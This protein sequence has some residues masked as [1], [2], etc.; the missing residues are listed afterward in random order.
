MNLNSLTEKCCKIN[1]MDVRLLY[2]VLPEFLT[3][4][5]VI[6][7]HLKGS[8]YFCA[9]S[10][11]GEKK[12]AILFYITLPA[13]VLCWDQINTSQHSAQEFIFLY[14]Q[15][16]QLHSHLL[17]CHFHRLSFANKRFHTCS[18]SCSTFTDYLSKIASIEA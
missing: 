17:I 11:G 15:C 14:I 1:K 9:L 13:D 5:L 16:W 12:S 10:P 2:W 3:P 18:L 6:A 7:Y 8:L 4:Y